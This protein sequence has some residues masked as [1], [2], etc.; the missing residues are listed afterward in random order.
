MATEFV[1]IP[2]PVDRVQEV[3][4]LLA[5]PKAQQPEARKASGEDALEDGGLTEADRDILVRAYRESQ[6]TMRTVFKYLAER[7]GHSVLMT[8][9]AAG[10]GRTPRQM[11]GALGAFG[12]RFANRYAKDGAK[13]PFAAWWDYER[14]MM[15]YR[16]SPEAAEVVTKLG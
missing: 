12:R 4:E 8:E 14:G 6:E 2:V 11:S 10:V 16:L 9:L 5:R 3:Y 15:V 7:A 13:W 1:S